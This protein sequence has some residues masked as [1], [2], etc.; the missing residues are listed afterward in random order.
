MRDDYFTPYFAQHVEEVSKDDA[1]G[2]FSGMNDYV[3]K[4][5]GHKSTTMEEFAHNYAS[6]LT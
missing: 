5:G 6:V 1:H 2:V 3:E 4:I